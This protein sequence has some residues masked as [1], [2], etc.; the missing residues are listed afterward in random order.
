MRQE[1]NVGYI[2]GHVETH[3]QK[4]HIDSAGFLTWGGAHYIPRAISGGVCR[5]KY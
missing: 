3:A 1:N 4:A 5:F 2:A